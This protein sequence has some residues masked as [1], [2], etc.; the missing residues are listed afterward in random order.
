M[1]C[2][3]CNF[4]LRGLPGNTCPECGSAFDPADPATF[5]N[6]LTS[7][8]WR[9]AKRIFAVAAILFVCAIIAFGVLFFIG[10]R[11]ATRAEERLQA[12]RMIG[13]LIAEHVEASPTHAWPTSWADLEKLPPRTSIWEWP[14]DAAKFKAIVTI[15]F[16]ATTASVL[17]QTPATCTA[18]TIT[19]GPDFGRPGWNLEMMF[20]RLRSLPK[21]GSIAPAPTPAVGGN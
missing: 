17:K 21:Q 2:I 12:T 10:V 3:S 20:D 15:D 13:D 18:V 19:P 4:D 11:T 14:K 8:F 9:I 16:S 6:A 7:P 1:Y 5:L